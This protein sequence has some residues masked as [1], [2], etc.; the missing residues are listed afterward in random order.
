AIGLA[1]IKTRQYD[2]SAASNVLESVEER[3][4]DL[5]DFAPALQS[6][7]LDSP[8]T[9]APAEDSSTS[10]LDDVLAPAPAENAPAPAED[11]PGAGEAPAGGEKEKAKVEKA[12][13]EEKS[14]APKEKAKAPAEGG[15]AGE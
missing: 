4:M 1:M 13:P 3:E 14:E 7:D 10:L 12:A 11:A 15:E 2:Q 9:P 6:P 8:V 5:P